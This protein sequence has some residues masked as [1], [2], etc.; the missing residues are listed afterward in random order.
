[1]QYQQAYSA[2]A[3]LINVSQTIFDTLLQSI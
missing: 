2:S 1:V 3:K